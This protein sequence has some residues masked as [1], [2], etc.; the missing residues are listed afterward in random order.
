MVVL[1]LLSTS[2]LFAKVEDWDTFSEQKAE[3]SVKYSSSNLSRIIIIRPKE[4][5]GTAINIYVDGEYLSSLLPGAYTEE[6]ICSGRHRI[7]MAYTNV[8]YKYWQ[9]RKGGQRVDF[10]SGE[11]QHVYMLKLEGTKLKFK[12]Y[13][14]DNISKVLKS[15]SKKQIHTIS[16]VNKKKCTQPANRSGNRR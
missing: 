15:Y 1:G 3:K 12:Y 16:R 6:L 8:A 14:S 11:K 4:L 13:T 2:T 5:K 7:N 10:K 9:K